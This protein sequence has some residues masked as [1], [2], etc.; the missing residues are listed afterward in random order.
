MGE[1]TRVEGDIIVTSKKGS[2]LES[3]GPSY[4]DLCNG[5]F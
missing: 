2:V 5:L 3:S 1:I 4:F